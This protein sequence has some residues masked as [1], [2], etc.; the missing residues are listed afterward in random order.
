[1]AVLA[2]TYRQYSWQGRDMADSHNKAVRKCRAIMFAKR[3]A[4]IVAYRPKGYWLDIWWKQ[5]H[6][7]DGESNRKWRAYLKGALPGERV[8]RELLAT[9]P[10]LR[11]ILINPLWWALTKLSADPAH[12]AFWDSCAEAI[13]IDGKPLVPFN[14]A[15]MESL[16]GTPTWTRLGYLLILLRSGKSAFADHRKWLKAH[17]FPYLCL[18]L[19]FYP[20]KWVAPLLFCLIDTLIKERLLNID[21]LDGWPESEE[22]FLSRLAL[23]KDFMEYLS[24]LNWVRSW[25]EDSALLVWLLVLDRAA[26]RA[27]I[28]RDL[29][30]PDR[31]RMRWRRAAVKTKALRVNFAWSQ[32]YQRELIPAD[33]RLLR[34][35]LFEA[36]WEAATDFVRNDQ[37]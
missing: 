3:L 9:L 1:M 16:C 33:R 12:R 11:S 36:D 34:R 24:Y 18:S 30:M 17:F 5:T 25:R 15:V 8:R 23:F 31:L 22:K 37:V 19:Q 6:G 35:F 20:I 28:C 4:D 32:C 21:R 2:G 14:N 7:L 29:N 13:T 10:R 26:M 27:I